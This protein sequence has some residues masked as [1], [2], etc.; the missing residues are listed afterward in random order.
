MDSSKPL[1]IYDGDCR[2]CCKWVERLRSFLGARIDYRPFQECA[3][4]F[5]QISPQQFEHSVHLIHPD[6]SF[7]SAAK[8]MFTALSYRMEGKPLLWFYQHLPFSKPVSE[9]L[10]RWIASH[11]MGISAIDRHLSGLTGIIPSYS[12]STWLFLRGMALVLA[13]AFSSLA[14]QVRG[15]IGE[16]GIAPAATFLTRVFQ[17][18]G[19]SSFHQAPTVF[20]LGDSDGMLLGV[21]IFGTLI[22]LCA[23]AGI[24]GASAFL[25]AW[26]L[27]L[28]LVT[29]G[30][31]F[32]SFQWDMLLLEATLLTVFLAPWRWGNYRISELKPSF[33]GRWLILFLLFRLMFASG[34]VKLNSGDP[35]WANLT[36]L[37]YHFETQPL[38]TLLAY[39]AHQLP[40]SILKLSTFIMFVIDLI[41]VFLLFGPRRLQLLA[42]SALLFLQIL[43]ALTGNYCFFNLLTALF[44][45]M[46]VDDESWRRLSHGKIRRPSVQHPAFR[47]PSWSLAP[48]A[49]LVLMVSLLTFSGHF[50]ASIPWPGWMY[51]SYQAIAPFRS[52]NS[53]GLFAVMT[54]TRPEIVMEGSHDGTVWLEYTFRWKPGDV[55]KAP[56][57]VAPHQPRLDWQMWFAALGN[58]QQNPWLISF[59]EKLLRGSPAILNLLDGNPFPDHPPKYIRA[60]VYDYQFTTPEEKR[61]SGQWW[62]ATYKGIYLPPI[63]LRE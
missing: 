23:M 22:S 31:P 34:L 36:A 37:S 4:A 5:P 28:S 1:L 41:V 40:A 57:L 43:I 52:I 13:I 18:L 12:V 51:S 59:A 20:W 6:G 7:C 39:Y 32:L 50:K 48:F 38:P 27:Y 44:C 26:F 56:S 29:A 47:L 49:M 16:N 11:R 8:A 25:A 10:Y 30:G 9:A 60:V 24:G 58:Y 19:L 42:A 17:Q 54:T 21:C 46:L 35:T 63:S 55:N 62:K 53:Y 3:A 33:L 14:L 45:L 15:L 61:G 2:F